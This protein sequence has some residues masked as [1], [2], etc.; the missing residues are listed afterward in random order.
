MNAQLGCSKDLR[1]RVRCL[2]AGAG[3]GVY[4]CHSPSLPA[5]W[6]SA[7]TVQAWNAYDL[8]CHHDGR[9]PAWSCTFLVEPAQRSSCSACGGACRAVGMER[10]NRTHTDLL[11]LF[12]SISKLAYLAQGP[13]AFRR[14]NELILHSVRRRETFTD[15]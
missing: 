7:C 14:V 1:T 9:V 15:N 3:D 8:L 10:R 2:S 6:R 11:S 13:Y 12:L 5:S 4:Q